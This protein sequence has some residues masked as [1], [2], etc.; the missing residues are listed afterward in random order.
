MVKNERL[1]FISVCIFIEGV[2]QHIYIYIYN[3]LAAAPRN[4]AI[5]Q[6]RG[7]FLSVYLYYSVQSRVHT[8]GFSLFVFFSIRG[9]ATS[10]LSNDHIFM[11]DLKKLRIKKLFSSRAPPSKVYMRRSCAA[12]VG[13]RRRWNQL[14]SVVRLFRRGAGR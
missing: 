13:R 8:S 4:T 7:N 2:T 11:R 1:P 3:T 9:S 5:D 10:W 6:S 14:Y 12:V